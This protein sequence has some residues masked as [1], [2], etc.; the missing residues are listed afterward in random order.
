M[1]PLLCGDRAL[2]K[3]PYIFDDEDD[4]S[5]TVWHNSGRAARWEEDENSIFW[6][7]LFYGS[8]P[9]VTTANLKLEKEEEAHAIVKAWCEEGSLP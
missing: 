3:E 9:W 1:T 4:E 2:T 6:L 5:C 8:D 7:T